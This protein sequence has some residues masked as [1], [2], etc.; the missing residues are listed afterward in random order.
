[1]YSSKY[2]ELLIEEL[3]RLPA[4]GQKS[5]QRLALHLLRAP[6][7]DALRLADAIRALREHVGFCKTCGNFSE[8]DVHR[9]LRIARKQDPAF[10]DLM[11]AVTHTGSRPPGELARLDVQ[12]FDASTSTVKLKHRKGKG[13]WKER[14]TYLTAEGVRFRYP[15][16][17]RIIT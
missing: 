7:E 15:Y 1:M 6:R 2:L 14:I 11:E 13:G 10:A 8:Q 4:I 3:T 5:A 12:D 17:F 9:L 16:I